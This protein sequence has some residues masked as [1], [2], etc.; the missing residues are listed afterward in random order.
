MCNASGVGKLQGF[1]KT[2]DM[3]FTL[4]TRMCGNPCLLLPGEN[5]FFENKNFNLSSVSVGNAYRPEQ[6]HIPTTS[7]NTTPPKCLKL[8]GQVTNVNVGQNCLDF[9]CKHINFE[10]T[11]YCWWRNQSRNRYLKN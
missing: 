5:S 4:A 2:H 9:E 11:F 8:S 1:Y 3:L 6:S 7:I 10:E